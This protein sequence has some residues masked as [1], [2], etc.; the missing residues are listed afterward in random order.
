MFGYINIHKPELKVKEYYE[1]K[2]FYCG[3]CYE[4]KRKYGRLGQM[5]LTYDM[6]FLILLLTSLYE[7]KP[8]QSQGRCLAHPMEKHQRLINCFTEYAADMNIALTYHKLLD[9][10]NDER[11][12]LHKGGAS[13]I[14]HKYKKVQEIYPRQCE[15]I[16]S[17]MNQ[18]RTLERENET[19]LDEISKPFGALMGELFV[20]HEDHWSDTLRRMGCFLGKYIYLLDA[21]L[22]REQDLKTG[23]FNPLKD[24]QEVELED[25]IKE[26]LTLLMAECTKEFEKLPLL[27]EGE[28]M[29][30]IL[31]AGVWK[32]FDK[33]VEKKGKDK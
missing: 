4:L 11:K 8:T 21:Y 23:S 19:D 32:A 25:R 28:L 22:D 14:S 29:R 33:K 7:K 17:C 3:L 20:Y 2:A 5:T 24:R 9:D 26:T 31:Y 13:L 6:T 27:W 12:L 15:A 30:N 16:E 1:Y 10:W 18:L